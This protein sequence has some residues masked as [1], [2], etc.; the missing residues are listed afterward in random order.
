MV[1][2]KHQCPY[3]N[4]EISFSKMFSIKNDLEYCCNNCHKVSSV[5][6][7]KKI[8][9]V[10]IALIAACAVVIFVFSFLLRMLIIGTLIIALLFLGFYILVP[11]FLKLSSAKGNENKK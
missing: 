8:N 2:K 6:I 9:N 7:N 5:K 11:N 3:C 1:L 10:V 4:N